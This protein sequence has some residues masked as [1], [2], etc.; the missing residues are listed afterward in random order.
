MKKAK[1]ILA[2]IAFLAILGG[3]FAFTAS[4]NLTKVHYKSTQ[5]STFGTIYTAA[6]A[7]CISTVPPV[8]WTATGDENVTTSSAYLTLQPATTVVTFTRIGGTQTIT[9]PYYSSCTL[10][11]TLTTSVF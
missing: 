6:A 8:F 3:V 11:T 4:R 1:L 5:Y 7:Y 10:T 2:S 9:L